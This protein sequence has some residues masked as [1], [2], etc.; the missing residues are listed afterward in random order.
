MQLASITL[1]RPVIICLYFIYMFVLYLGLLSFLKEKG[2]TTP[3][4]CL[5]LGGIVVKSLLLDLVI[6]GSNLV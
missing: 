6:A 5:G 1:S 2:P 4:F 3:A